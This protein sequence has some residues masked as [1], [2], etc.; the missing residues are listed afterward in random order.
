[1]SRIS[2]RFVPDGNCGLTEGE[3]TAR[4]AAPAEIAPARAAVKDAVELAVEISG[5]RRGHVERNK[6]GQT[7]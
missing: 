6:E 2:S 5:A 3:L 7:S 4:G 1:M